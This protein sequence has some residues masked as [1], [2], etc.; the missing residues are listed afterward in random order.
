M[1]I[2]P[3]PGPD[4]AGPLFEVGSVCLL[5]TT[6]ECEANSAANPIPA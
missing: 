1:L 4:A 5:C 6:G 2:L 3:D